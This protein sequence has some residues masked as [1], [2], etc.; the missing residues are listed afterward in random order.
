MTRITEAGLVEATGLEAV[1]FDGVPDSLAALGSGAGSAGDVLVSYSPRGGG[2]ALFALLALAAS[3]EGF[4][5]TAVAIAPEW[6]AAARRVLGLVSP[7]AYTL[8]ALVAPQLEPTAG[9]VEAGNGEDALPVT[10]ARVVGAL[11]R[12]GDRDLFRRALA[13]LE[14]LAA[15]HGG[16]VRGVEDR[17]ELVLL[18]RR[19]A[20][21][22]A[23]SAGVQLQMILPERATVDLTIDGLAT[24]LDRLEGSL[25]KRLN[26]RKV[27]GSDDGLRAALLP[28][29]E[30]AGELRGA[31]PWPLAQGDSEAIDLVGAGSEEGLVAAAAR[32]R[33]D[34]EALCGIVTAAMDPRLRLPLL[35]AGSELPLPLGPPRL[36][37][38]ASEFE[39]SALGVLGALGLGWSAY[40]VVS[41]RAGEWALERRDEASPVAAPRRPRSRGRGGAG[42]TSRSAPESGP[43]RS[44]EPSARAADDTAEAR[45]RSSRSTRGRGARAA[46]DRAPRDV[47]ER[48]PAAES[49]ESKEKETSGPRFDEV[50]LF[51]LDDDSSR[52]ADSDR[53]ARRRGR[54]RRRGRRGRGSASTAEESGDGGD[55]PAEIRTDEKPD[56]RSRRPGRR[57]PQ[58]VQEESA[59]DD[60]LGDDETLPALADD[61]P[62]VEVPE[63]SYEDEDPAEEGDA[64]ADGAR[65]E[66]E[67]RRRARLAKTVDRTPPPEAAPRTPRRRAAFVAHAD[68]Q[69]VLTA[70][71]LAR[72]ARLVEGFWVYPQED[73]MTFFRSIATDLREETPI[74]LVGFNASP[75]ARDTIQ[76]AALYRGRLD[77]YDHHD[78][79]PE[80]IVTLQ[81]AI[82]EE[83]VHIDPGAGSSLAGVIAERTRR[84]RFSDKLAELATGRFTQHDYERW[85]RVWWHR[86]GEICTRRG[87]RRSDV[88]PLLV[89]RP[90]D[91]AKE[92]ARVTPPPPPPEV[93]YVAQR[94][95]RLVHFGGY[96][97]VV[98][99]VPDSLDLH[100]MARIARERY[101]AQLSLAYATGGELLVL[102]GDEGRSRR[103]LD[104][105]SMADHLATKHEW[106]SALR[107]DDHVARIRI[108]NLH[109]F[110]ERLDEVIGEIAMG[111]SIVEG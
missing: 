55:P 52:D 24:A 102:G 60:G 94:D 35:S 12:A 71:L 85:G 38:A 36:L 57:R 3:R 77:W 6:N 58:P 11:A 49:K 61:L 20:A 18:A 15:K 69:S 33:L 29:L 32:G 90:S 23:R 54:G 42:R 50:S 65:K 39:E 98:L 72:D 88:E 67:L 78:W 107:D 14:G 16:A 27:R 46:T 31:I 106:I 13:G 87:E 103:G 81:Q 105:G 111:R 43:E 17:V 99:E 37:L 5:G 59:E 26:D 34:V 40:D 86:L 70:V 110:P 53:G 30:R 8:R 19:V 100:L 96:V 7:R 45:P 1:A 44:E 2:E 48:P 104:L 101:D 93:E 68:R 92:A 82:G 9:V 21:L 66:R 89:G 62:E 79:P 91:L 4:E 51:D 83:A 76:A 95:F 64:E 73:L 84:S 63:L 56:D 74:Y 75:P 47:E 28:I 109:A 22:E 41:R 97:M 10:P 108:A 80:D 25:R